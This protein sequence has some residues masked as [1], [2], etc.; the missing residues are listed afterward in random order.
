LANLDK[1]NVTNIDYR[2]AYSEDF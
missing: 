2:S 1:D